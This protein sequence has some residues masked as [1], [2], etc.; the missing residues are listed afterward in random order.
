MKESRKLLA[1]RISKASTFLIFLGLSAVIF[2][3]TDLLKIGNNSDK[4]IFL[5]LG[6]IR[7]ILNQISIN[8]IIA[9]GMTLVI[10]VNGID[11]SVGSMVAVAGVTL[12]VFFIQLEIPLLISYLL[13]LIIGG[14]VGFSNGMVI[15]KIKL[16]PFIVTL[17]SF[18][19]FRGLAFILVNGQAKFTTDESFKIIGNRFLFGFMP[20]SILAMLAIFIFYHLLLSRTSLGR[21]IYLTGGNEEAARFSG[22]R[23]DWVRISAYTLTGISATVSGILLASRLGSGSPNVGVGYELDAIAATVVGGTSFTGGMGTITGTLI[24]ALILGVISNGLNLLGISPFFQQIVRGLIILSAVI[25]DS[26]KR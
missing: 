18:Q 12:G 23:I 8:A 19:I 25:L 9:F 14:L 5:E 3:L 10:L 24:G 21:K 13:V 2:I 26:R 6:N 17:A 22:I 15:T 16:P 4:W 20:I 11:L 7:N 1:G